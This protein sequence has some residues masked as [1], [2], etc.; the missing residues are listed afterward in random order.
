VPDRS[1]VISLEHRRPFVPGAHVEGHAHRGDDTA[2]YFEA[3][4][5]A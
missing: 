5:S 1:P 2:D 3:T 4:E